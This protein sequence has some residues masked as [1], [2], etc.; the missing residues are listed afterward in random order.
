MW[1]ANDQGQC[2]NG[3]QNDTWRPM[4][5]VGLGSRVPKLLNVAAGAPGF[6]NLSWSCSTGEYF[7]VEM[8]SDPSK[9]FVTWQT[10]L[11][12][13]PPT[14]VVPAPLGAGA[15]FYRLRF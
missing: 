2:G 15:S 8:S 7:N 6:A 11:L 3:T 14:A 9:G 13:T 10:N 4:P 1:G 12:A 5:V